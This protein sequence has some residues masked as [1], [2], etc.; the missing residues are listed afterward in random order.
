M[1]GHK[2]VYRVTPVDCIR[3]GS[4]IHGGSPMLYVVF[5]DG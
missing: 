2:V 4:E 5:N 3:N 1:S